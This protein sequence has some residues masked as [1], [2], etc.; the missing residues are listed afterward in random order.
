[1]AE[2]PFK[3]RVV[4]WELTLRCNMRC[5]HCGSRAGAPRPDELS[6]A[7]GLDLI[8]QLVDL[9]T[10]VVTL[11]GG[12]PLMHPSWPVYAKR[13]VDSKVNTFLITNGL[14]LEEN[15]GRIKD[16]GLRRIGVS[17]DGLEAVHDRIRSMPDSFAKAIR[18][19]RA[20]K[21]AGLD[22]GA[23]THVSRA[24]FGELEG[25]YKLFSEIPLDYWQVQITFRQGRMTEHE[26]MSLD[27]KQLPEVAAFVRRKQALKG[28]PVVPGDNLGYYCVPDIREKPWKGCFAGRHLVGIDADGSVKG[29]L[30][31][32]REFIEGNIRKEPLRRIWE[33]PQRFKY[34]RYFSADMLEGSCKGCPHGDPCRAGCTVTAYSATGNRF[35]NP[36]CCFRWL[37]EDAA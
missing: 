18:A 35:D 8:A 30:S 9:G 22:I 24:N 32:P 20:A 19:V 10:Q 33:D 16:L 36:Y 4:G 1:M 5:I 28:L 11:S 31:L 12:E 34:N 17:L 15:I 37:R 23:V 25:M 27:P 21:K 6:E 13:F 29:C 2:F 3:P 7:E 14:L 26:D